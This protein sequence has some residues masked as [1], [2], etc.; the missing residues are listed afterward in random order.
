[1]RF[2]VERTGFGECRRI[3]R[4]GIPVGMALE[5][6]SGK[7]GAFDMDERRLTTEQFKSPAMVRRWFE[8][9]ATK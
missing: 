4:D 6:M 3:E 9:Q 1:M 2:T 5:L 8:N 7:W